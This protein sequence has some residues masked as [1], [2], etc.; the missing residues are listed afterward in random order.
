MAAT[1]KSRPGTLQSIAGLIVLATL[2]TA[3]S[4]QN[5]TPSALHYWSAAEPTSGAPRL[6]LTTPTHLLKV[7]RVE[8]AV[9]ESHEGTSDV[10]FVESGNGSILVG[11][12]IEGAAPLSDMPG[13]LRGRSIKGGKS[14][15]LKTVP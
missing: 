6:L 5:S 1:T 4:A 13:E 9:A 8:A 14:Y 11:G 12:E 2:A 10:F 3:A 15:E 7:I